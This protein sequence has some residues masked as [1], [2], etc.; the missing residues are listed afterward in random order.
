MDTRGLKLDTP[1]KSTASINLDDINGDIRTVWYPDP[2]SQLDVTVTQVHLD[3]LNT[4]VT[5][6]EIPWKCKACQYNPKGAQF[7]VLLTMAGGLK[8]KAGLEVGTIE[9][10]PYAPKAGEPI[11]LGTNG[12]VTVPSGYRS[13]PPPPGGYAPPA[14]DTSPSID[15]GIDNG[16]GTG[17][18]GGGPG[19]RPGMETS[20]DR[21]QTHEES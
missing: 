12:G 7:T 14:R 15:T 4:W 11:K 18:L 10:F 19:P 8:P 3:H 1:T 13:P 6:L 16:V 17:V 21:Q 2:F 20:D 9:L 5:T